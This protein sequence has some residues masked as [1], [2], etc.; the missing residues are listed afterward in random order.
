MNKRPNSEF[1]KSDVG[2]EMR[3]L[4]YSKNES[5]SNATN[6]YQRETNGRVSVKR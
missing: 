5:R 3:N 4:R 2:V 1:L 6:E